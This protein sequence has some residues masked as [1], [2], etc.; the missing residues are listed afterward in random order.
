[1]VYTTG[2]GASSAALLE[3]FSQALYWKG[4]NYSTLCRLGGISLLEA[5][6]RGLVST[7]CRLGG[8]SLLEAAYTSTRSL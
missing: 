8:I 1:M 4:L 5:V 7:L 3:K 6:H 2:D